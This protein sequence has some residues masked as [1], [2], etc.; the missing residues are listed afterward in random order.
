PREADYVPLGHRSLGETASLPLETALEALGPL[1]EDAAIP[2]IGHDLKFDAIV[3]A[4]HG[5][6]LRGLETDTMISS[7]LIDATRSAHRLEDL[8]L[9]HTSYK[10]L[11]EEDVCGRG[12]KAVSLADVPVEAAI[13][14]ACERADI[15]G[16]LAPRFR[17]LLKKEQLDEV[18]TSLELP[19]IPVLVAIE[20][21]GVRIDGP[22]L[23]AQALRVDQELARRTG[24]IFR[25]A[26]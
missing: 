10:A 16:Q 20:R 6:T 8:G 23:A 21:A 26:G 18:Y 2:K 13:D 9:E 7:Y 25:L 14:Y 3:L 17:D 22:A 12:V 15:A 5:I 19:L 11:T 24:D 1:L 4:R